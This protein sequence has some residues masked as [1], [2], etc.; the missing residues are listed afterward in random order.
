MRSREEILAL[1]LIAAES[2]RDEEFYIQALQR[3]NYLTREVIERWRIGKSPTLR[4]ALATGLSEIELR[5]VGLLVDPHDD[6]PDGKPYMHFRSSLV[7]PFFASG[8]D[9][10]AGR[11]GYFTSRRLSDYAADG[12][13][14]DKAKKALSMPGPR[15]FR[16]RDT[17]TRGNA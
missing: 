11:P 12:T 8:E 4:Q 10:Q 5:E 13:P 3:K 1:Y 9:R 7:I 2:V 17:E 6:G 16:R 14:L 15:P